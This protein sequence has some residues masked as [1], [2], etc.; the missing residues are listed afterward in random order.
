MNGPQRRPLWQFLAILVSVILPV[1]C[2]SPHPSLTP[3][4]LAT[5]TKPLSPSPSASPTSRPSASPTA[6]STDTSPINLIP[7]PVSL[8]T[9]QGVFRLTT[10]STI[11]IDPAADEARPVAVYLA[12]LLN[13]STGFSIPVQELDDDSALQGSLL[14][15]LTVDDPALGPEGYE[16]TV[17]PDHVSIAANEPAG[18]FYGVQTLR[19]L[20]PPAIESGS[21]RP[22]PWNVPSVSIRD[23]PRFAWRGAMLDV[24]RHFFSVDDVERYI[25]LLSFYKLNRLHLHLSDDQGWRIQI[26]AWPELTLHGGSLEVGGT[27]GGY[28]TQDDYTHIIEYAASRFVAIVPEIDMPGHVN[29][30]LSSYAELNCS[31]IATQLFTGID[32]GFSS[33]CISKDITYT[34]V[35]DVLTELAVLTPTPYLHVGGDEA[36]AT[37]ASDYVNFIKRVQAIVEQR[38]KVMVGWEEIAKTSLLPTSIAQHWNL[39]DSLAPQAAQQGVKVIMSPANKAYIDMKYD[40]SSPLG[41]TWAGDL[42]VET[43]YSWD[44][45]AQVKGVTE[46][47]VI[48]VEAPLWSETLNTID[49]IEYMAFPRL[50]GIAEIGWTPQAKRDWATYKTRL[51]VHGPRLE[52]LEVNFY[53]SPEIPWP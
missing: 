20:F 32:V 25:D 37:E 11:F 53:P 4:P 47:D 40:P 17:T 29:A 13:K 51:A 18:L 48:G 9:D 43:A 28:Y 46:K 35:E 26:K 33:L 49:D 7:L 34:F 15:S 36:S 5:M 2:S 19:Q 45:A 21:I 27:P 8:K 30:A 24:A 50:P 1:S 39:N 38:G 42:N 22:G 16:L 52:L 6:A 23:F 44:P 14:L 31:G 12:G 41:L 10:D 3:T